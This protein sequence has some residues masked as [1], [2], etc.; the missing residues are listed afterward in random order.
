MGTKFPHLF[1]PIQI[2]TRI[3]KNRIEAAPAMFAFTHLINVPGGK[4]LGFNGN[5]PERSFR[6]LRDKAKGGAASVVLGELSPNHTNCKRFPFEPD[7]DYKVYSGPYFDIF[8]KTSDAIK[9]YGAFAMAELLVVG[10]SKTDLGDGVDV[11]GPSDRIRPDGTQ[12]KAFTKDEIVE[13]IQQHIDACKW[14]R[15]C[16]W[17]GIVIHCGHGWLPAQFLSSQVNERTD[18]YGGS[19]ENRARFTVELLSAIREA[20]GKDYVIEIRV[21]GSEN[22]PGGITIDDTVEYCKLIEKYV[23]LIHVSAG[24]YWKPGRSFE[25]S[26]ALAPH[27]INVENAAKV[28]Q[29][30]H[31]PVAVVG[32]INSPE[33]AEQIIAEGKVDM[34]SLGRQLFADPEFPNKAM[35]GQEDQI[36]RCLRCARCYPGPIGEHKTEKPFEGFAA[37]LSSCSINPDSVWAASHHKVFPEEMPAP[38]ASRKVLVVGGGCGGMQAAITACDRGH[39][40]ILAEKESQLGGILKFTDHTDH[41]L[42][43]RNFKNLL[44]HEVERRDIEVRLNCE[45]KP[46]NIKEIAPEALIIAVGSDDLILP[47]PGIENAQPAMDAYYDDFQQIGKSVIVL[48]GGLVGCE[49]ALDFRDLGAETTIVERQECLMP[50]LLG[51]YRTA[52]HDRI[53]QTGVKYEVNATVVEVGK[54]YVIVEMP[55]GNRNTLHADSIVNAMGRKAKSALAEEL[56]EAADGIKVSVIGDCVVAKQMAEAIDGG[57]TAAMEII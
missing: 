41:K 38:Q 21:S 16:G 37:P 51:I 49:V 48:G 4:A 9:S 46:E 39:K 43:I 24:H 57:W 25:F 50:D 52:V 1:S 7:I 5:E 2:G 29:A 36:R 22:L 34:I 15:E 26:T 6:M 55:D 12:V 20:M 3:F 53:D 28:K 56:K 40:V 18:E 23:D 42:D 45:V 11:K 14:L 19:F 10:E 32:G 27:G 8:K 31:V 13:L 17:E 47:I 33:Y 54:D 35:N 44:V 30:V